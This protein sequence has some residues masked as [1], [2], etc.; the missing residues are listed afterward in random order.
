MATSVV[1]RVALGVHPLNQVKNETTCFLLVL[2]VL[3]L[4]L[5]L[6]PS[7]SLPSS[8]SPPP[9]PCRRR[10][11]LPLLL[12]SFFI[13]R[14]GLLSHH[15][16]FQ[17]L[18]TVHCA[19]VPLVSAQICRLSHGVPEMFIGSSFSPCIFTVRRHGQQVTA[20]FGRDRR[21]RPCAPPHRVFLFLS[22]TPCQ[23]YFPLVFMAI[24]RQK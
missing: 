1:P 20:S 23:I 22:T 24:S 16:P 21:G 10:R 2:L 17:T 11:P 5:L 6:S 8:T 13:L 12:F 18:R 3:R 15:L 9:S 7:Q 14:L 19:S 4:L